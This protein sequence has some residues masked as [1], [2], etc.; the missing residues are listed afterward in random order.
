MSGR[1]PA[2]PRQVGVISDTHGLMRASA[3]TALR[4]SDLI[5]HAGDIGGVEVLDELGD[6]APVVAVR[7]N[8]DIDWPHELPAE[9]TLE[10]G[11]LLVHLLHDLQ[12]L[13]FRPETA[14]IAIVISGHTHRP[15]VERKD[16]VLYLNP[17]SAGPRRFDLPVCVARLSLGGKEP[18][19]EI[20]KLRVR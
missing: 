3:L 9:Q 10:L 11:G 6:L 1:L 4:G 15:R 20:L 13:D 5:I 12:K 7:G 17:G 19:V 2:A 14:G 16:G 18:E 8:C